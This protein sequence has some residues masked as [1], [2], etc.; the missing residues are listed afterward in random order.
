M[1]GV[2]R[3]MKMKMEGMERYKKESEC[4]NVMNEF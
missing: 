3:D 4:K 1:R 2:I